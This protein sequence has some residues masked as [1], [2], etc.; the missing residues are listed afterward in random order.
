M[1]WCRAERTRNWRRL[2]TS[3][4]WQQ[5]S[6]GTGS[7]SDGTENGRSGA[8]TKRQQ[9][10]ADTRWTGNG[11]ERRSQDLETPPPTTPPDDTTTWTARCV[12][13]KRFE[14]LPRLRE[15]RGGKR[16]PVDRNRLRVAAATSRP[17]RSGD[18]TRS[19]SS[20]ERADLFGGRSGLL[21]ETAT[22]GEGDGRPRTARAE[23]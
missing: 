23:W 12:R 18:L 4:T 1:T 5:G 15:R 13:G 16:E 7:I 21:Q 11:T 9:G 10:R 22:T 20:G 14:G 3:S 8:R 6:P 19:S 17:R 2:A